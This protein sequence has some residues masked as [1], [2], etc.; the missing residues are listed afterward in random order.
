MRHSEGFLL[1]KF[2]WRLF[3]SIARQPLA[4]STQAAPIISSLVLCLTVM[5][6]HAVSEVLRFVAAALHDVLKKAPSETVLLDNYTRVCVV[7]SEIIN[8]VGAPGLGVV[9]HA[10]Q[11]SMRI[12]LLVARL[13]HLHAAY[14]IVQGAKKVKSS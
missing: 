4:K 5:L 3:T 13:A 2:S 6:P 11:A 1:R 7:L 10:C 9:P 14:R 12:G 8:E